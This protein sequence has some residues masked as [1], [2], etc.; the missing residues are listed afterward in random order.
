M[1]RLPAPASAKRAVLLVALIVV[2]THAFAADPMEEKAKVCT[3]C[4]GESGVPQLQY[5]AGLQIGQY[6]GN[7]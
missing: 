4:H 2:S 3:A 5:L 1:C 7:K 6:L